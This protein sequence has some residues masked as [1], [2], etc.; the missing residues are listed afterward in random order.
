M[1]ARTLTAA[2]VVLF[3]RASLGCGPD[4]SGS[5]PQDLPDQCPSAVP[6]F[7][8]D[9]EPIFERRCWH[10]HANGGPEAASHNFSTYDNIYAQRSAILNQVYACHMPPAGQ[11]PPTSDERAKLLAW[12]V[13]KA[14]NN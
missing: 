6:S 5:C 3:V 14:P 11:T 12:L 2:T 1:R 13:C 7:K 8:T 10:C 9:V 4:A